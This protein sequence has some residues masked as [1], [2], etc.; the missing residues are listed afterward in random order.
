MTYCLAIR[1]DAGIVFAADTRTNAG[2]DYV[3]SY[4]KVHIF[5]PAAD[6]T[7]VLLSAGNLATTTELMHRLKHDVANSA[8]VDSFLG[9]ELPYQAAQYVG[10]TSRHIQETHSAA[11]LA[12][13][14]AGEVTLIMGAQIGSAPQQLFLIYPQGNFIEASPETPYLQIGENKYG[15]P[16]LDRL[17]T[18]ALSLDEAARLCV[19][20]L[21]ATI[22]SN[23]TVGAPLDLVVLPAT[24]G[25]AVDMRLD[26]DD[27]LYKALR[28]AW[29]EG[30]ERAFAALPSF[31][32]G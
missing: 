1:T 23:M 22:R 10:R 5:Q 28:A 4:R 26:E 25:V 7:F 6:R 31:D 2:V 15:K 3:T 29:Q 16:V 30:L 9:C 27:D 17:G 12:S 24:G 18:A 32:W 20:S 13:G 21:D 14:V 8:N 11:L 19:L